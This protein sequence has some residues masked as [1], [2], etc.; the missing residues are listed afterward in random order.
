MTREIFHVGPISVFAGEDAGIE[1]FFPRSSGVAGADDQRGISGIV[2]V[3]THG[4]RWKD[5]PRRYS[6]HKTL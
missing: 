6:P 3:I 4:L 1:P 5:A 2:Y